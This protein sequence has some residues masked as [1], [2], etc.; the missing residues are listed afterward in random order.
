MDLRKDSSVGACKRNFTEYVL[1]SIAYKTLA[2]I[3]AL[4]KKTLVVKGV[5]ASESVKK[6][7]FVTKIFFQVTLND[8]LK[9]CEK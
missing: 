5:V 1:Q 9:S 4:T 8:V 7:K 6:G 3:G 2:K